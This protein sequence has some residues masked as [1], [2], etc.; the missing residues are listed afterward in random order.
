VPGFFCFHGEEAMIAPAMIEKV[1]RLVAT[2][3][4]SLRKIARLSGV[5]RGTVAAVAYGAR[6]DRRPAASDDLQEGAPGPIERCPECGALGE[7]PCRACRVRQWRRIQRRRSLP[8][9]RQETSEVSK[10]SE[11][12]DESCELA[13]ELA[14]EHRQRYEELHARRMREEPL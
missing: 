11:V 3:K 8:E 13:L 2:G 7:S 10:T 1:R 9:P 4:H 5:S 14:G 12:C 6:R